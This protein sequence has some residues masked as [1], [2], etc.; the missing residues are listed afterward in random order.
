[1]RAKAGTCYEN[2]RVDREEAGEGPQLH[3]ISSDSDEAV[4]AR[5]RAYVGN[6]S[7]PFTT[8][9]ILVNH[10]KCV[11]KKIYY[12]GAFHVGPSSPTAKPTKKAPHRAAK[13]TAALRNARATKPP[14]AA[15]A[16]VPHSRPSGSSS[17]TLPAHLLQLQ[18]LLGAC[19]SS[20]VDDAHK[21]AVSSALAEY[22]S[23]VVTGTKM[24]EDGMKM[25]TQG[26]RQLKMSQEKLVA[27]I[28]GIFDRAQSH[29]ES[30]QS[31]RDRRAK[32]RASVSFL[33]HRI[34][35]F[36]LFSKCASIRLLF[37]YFP[38]NFRCLPSNLSC[39]TQ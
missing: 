15:A 19:L 10:T 33:F 39:F 1:M 3:D 16:A 9:I 38:S 17:S 36:V 27:D 14:Y 7:C 31:P 12:N 20:F 34:F 6:Y 5:G 32:R 28:K 11:V 22:D 18:P 21:E 30:L 24:M 25:F 37:A 13:S 8:D 2:V 29:G 23:R 26:Q 35:A 4:H